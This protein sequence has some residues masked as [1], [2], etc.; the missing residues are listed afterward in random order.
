MGDAKDGS[1]WETIKDNLTIGP[2]PWYMTLPTVLSVAGSVVGCMCRA[3]AGALFASWLFGAA[4]GSGAAS[5][6]DPP[7]EESGGG[8]FG[9]IFGGVGGGDG[10]GEEKKGGSDE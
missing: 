9:G 8:W 7:P 5:S 6:S 2:F 1:T 4:G 10:S 3:C